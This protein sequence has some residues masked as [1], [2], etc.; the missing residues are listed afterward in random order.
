MYSKRHKRVSK[1]ELSLNCFVLGDN[2]TFTAVVPKKYISDSNLTEIV[3]SALTVSNFTKIIENQVEHAV[4]NPKDPNSMTLWKVDIDDGSL[5]DISTVKDI[6]DNFNGKKMKRAYLLSDYFPK[7]TVPTLRNIHIIIVPATN[8]SNKRI[9]LEDIGI[10]HIH[11]K[12]TEYL[13][14]LLSPFNEPVYCDN[15]DL[16]FKAPLQRKLVASHYL[17]KEYPAYF[18]QE[19]LEFLPDVTL[20][21]GD[22]M[23]LYTGKDNQE[24]E[25]SYMVDNVIRKM[26]KLAIR[27]IG[28][29]GFEWARNNKMNEY[30]TTTTHKRNVRPDVLVYCDE[31]LVILGEVKADHSTLATAAED[32]DYYFNNWNT[33]AFGDLPLVFAFAAV[34]SYIQF[35]Y[36]HKVESS[37]TPKREKIGDVLLLGTEVKKTPRLKL[38]KTIYRKNGTAIT[39]KSEEIRKSINVANIMDLK[40]HMDLYTRILKEHY[41]NITYKESRGRI[42]ITYGPVGYLCTPKNEDELRYAICDILEI[43]S[44]LHREEVVHRDIRWDN[45]VKLTNGKWLL[46]DFEEAARIG[47]ERDTLIIS[48]PEYENGTDTCQASGDIWMIGKLMNEVK[49]T[50]S[51]KAKN[52]RD[53]LMIK[54]FNLRLT[55]TDALKDD[56]IE[57]M[58]CG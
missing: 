17:C 58:G 13:Q 35:Y 33:L 31:V 30:T 12:T 36:F 29:S 49:F 22:A 50:L 4:P 28:K 56:W 10:G 41:E 18:D 32:L 57:E 24:M 51:E 21:V 40:F 45:V 7:D 42:N 6:E 34:G 46:I 53:K 37:T 47:D 11:D 2:D 20:A 16:Y 39:I 44:K 27:Y 8:T 52:F 19:D 5:K 55:A 25:T 38:F 26:V 3:Y 54:D 1:M 14:E 23:E 15:V 9:K 43:V 48:A